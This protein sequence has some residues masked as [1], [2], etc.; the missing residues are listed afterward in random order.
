MDFVAPSVPDRFQILSLDGGGIRGVFTAAVLAA[1]EDDLKTDVTKHFDL[2]AGTSTGGIVALALGLGIRPR[3]ILEFY[4]QHGPM[5]FKKRAGLAAVQH[6]VRR[7]YSR[8][9]LEK[10]VR[11]IFGDRTFGESRVRLIIPSFNLDEDEVYNFRTPHH[12]RLR[13]DYRVPAW[14]VALATSAAPTYFSPFRGVDSLRL[15]DGGLWANNPALVALIEAHKT[16][17]VP[18][19]RIA[20]LSIGTMAPVV[21]RPRSL[22]WGGLLAWAPHVPAL[23]ISATSVSV[24]N[25][26][27]YLLG[28]RFLRVDPEVPDHEVQLDK[29][30][31]AETFLGRARHYSRTQMPE[32]ARVF[33]GHS[34]TPYSPCHRA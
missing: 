34:A 24:V 21:R 2:I 9:P 19:D 27:R 23:I 15:A 28:D 26:T 11:L 30:E 7:K 18:L 29:V 1:I 33:A 3:E 25:H 5:I 13:R 16:L 20:M 12:E 32:I 6:W 17:E 8:A 10:A 31:A 22:N 14:K 4:L